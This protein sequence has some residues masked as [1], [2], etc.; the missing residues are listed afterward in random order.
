M[1]E[2]KLDRIY[3]YS[4]ND[5]RIP[6]S[7]IIVNNESLGGGGFGE[8][9]KVQRETQGEPPENQFFALKR[10]KKEGIINDKDKHYRVLSEIKIHRTLNNKYICKYEHSFEDEKAI[11]IIMEFCERKSLDDYLKQRKFF[12]EYETRYYMFQVLLGLKYLRRKKVIH[13]DLTLANLFLK[14]YKTVKIGDFG[15]SY[16]E[17]ENEEKSG[18]MCGTQGYFTPE[19][20][21]TKYSYKTDIFCFGVCIYHMMTGLTLFKDSASSFD[22]I[23]KNDI[24]YDEKTKFSKE[25]KN[26]FEQ[27]FVF[28][29]K[30]IDLEDIYNHPFFNKGKGLI[31]VD[32]PNYFDEKMNKKDFEEKIKN[33]EKNVIMTDVSYYPRK[34]ENL[35]NQK[36]NE[37][38]N[39]DN[40]NKNNNNNSSKKKDKGDFFQNLMLNN[41][42][43]ETGSLKEKKKTNN[44]INNINNNDE[45]IRSKE[46]KETNSFNEEKRYSDKKLPLM[47]LGE[48]NKKKMEKEKQKKVSIKEAKKPSL[49]KIL[50]LNDSIHELEEE[51]QEQEKEKEDKDKNFIIAN[52]L[53]DSNDV[54]KLNNNE[55]KNINEN[56]NENNNNKYFNDVD[57]LNPKESNK[58]MEELD[59]SSEKTHLLQK[60]YIKNIINEN[61]NTGIGYQLNNDDIGILF[62][63]DSI[64]T[65]FSENKN[66]I[67]YRNPPNKLH[68]ITFPVN[69][70][71]DKDLLNKINFF[72]YIIEEAKKRKSRMQLKNNY[73]EN[74]KNNYDLD[75][76]V[77]NEKKNNIKNKSDVY[78][79]KYKKNNYAHFFILSN[80]NIQIKYIDG[81]D[82]IF[83]CS[84]NK[85][86][87][88]ISPNG[89][90]NEF[91]LGLDNE[92]SNFSC[93]EPKIN[94][95][96]KYAIKEITK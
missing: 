30:R 61:D 32:F 71:L 14:D 89:N 6:I 64:M 53:N 92:F 18:L 41:K 78:L 54:F 84:K 57:T 75:D 24:I 46:K 68:K 55:N 38:D 7:Y 21:Q 9:F 36:N 67:Y 90:K 27:I 69:Y 59:I 95:R 86:I 77:I 39:N 85:K 72:G 63:D 42:K 87:I 5:S 3:D 40:D 22:M 16:V 45:E 82:V 47:I 43:R 23:K 19:S 88:Y 29:N 11:Y 66:L 96:I 52:N 37:N 56:N 93:K 65:K 8:V 80:N 70:Q 74:S 2:G 83:C 33:L 94:K 48:L 20:L 1:K 10:I 44:I 12:T 17:T 15:L 91:E 25:C 13:R 60:I 76:K 62:N 79:L 4:T 34:N 49:P 51:E 73:E 50:N 35:I 81:V 28:E 58:Y 26:L 31:D